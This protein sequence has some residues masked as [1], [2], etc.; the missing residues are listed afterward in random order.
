MFRNIHT[1]NGLNVSNSVAFMITIFFIGSML[2][3]S[4]FLTQ[5]AFADSMSERM[6]IR[7]ELS[8]ISSDDQNTMSASAAQDDQSNGNCARGACHIGPPGPQGPAGPQGPQ[9]IQGPTGPQ[10]PK[11]DTGPQG[12]PGAMLGPWIYLTFDS[13]GGTNGNHD[14]TCNVHDETG[15]TH[16]TC[17]VADPAISGGVN[18]GNCVTNNN[19]HLQCTIPPTPGVFGCNLQS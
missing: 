10:G 16:L 17:T 5:L 9:G 6:K 8:G 2:L 12:P 3:F 14:V 7:E 15:I 19:K 11:G 13:C 1:N 4:T 18:V